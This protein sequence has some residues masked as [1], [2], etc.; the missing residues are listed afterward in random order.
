MSSAG[1]ELYRGS[2]TAY[3]QQRQERW[4]LRMQIFDLNKPA[5]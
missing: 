1:I 2:Y 4:D 5:F 3:V